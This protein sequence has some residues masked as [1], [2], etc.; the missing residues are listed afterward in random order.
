MKT[1]LPHTKRNS[2]EQEEVSLY[3]YATKTLGKSK[4][5]VSE[6]A[7]LQNANIGTL[8]ETHWATLQIATLDLHTFM[9]ALLH[10]RGCQ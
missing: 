6:K 7:N 5:V 2:L 10:K 1:Y 8:L 3:G 9:C 4:A